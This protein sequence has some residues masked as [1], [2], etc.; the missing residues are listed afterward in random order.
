MEP[1]KAIVGIE[2]GTV[3]SSIGIWTGNAIRNNTIPSCVAF[4]DH[5]EPITG[6]K[7]IEQLDTNVPNTIVDARRLI[8]ARYSDIDGGEDLI[9]LWPF[10]VVPSMNDEPRFL[11]RSLSTLNCYSPEEIVCMILMS[12]KEYAEKELGYNR[13][14]EVVIDAVISVP[15]LFSNSQ[16][17]AT[18]EAARMAAARMR[19]LNPN[20]TETAIFLDSFYEDYA[21][22]V[23]ITQATVQETSKDLF[24]K[25]QKAVAQCLQDSRTF[26]VHQVILVGGCSGI[27]IIREMLKVLCGVNELWE[28]QNQRSCVAQGATILAASLSGEAVRLP[29]SEVTPMTLGVECPEDMPMCNFIP[30]YT[31]VPSTCIRQSFKTGADALGVVKVAVYEGENEVTVENNLLGY[32]IFGGI[33]PAERG[34]PDPII[35]VS[36]AIDNNGTVIVSAVAEDKSGSRQLPRPKMFKRKLSSEEFLQLENDLEQEEVKRKKQ[37][38]RQNVMQFAT[39]MCRE[40]PCE[41]IHEAFSASQDWRIKYAVGKAESLLNENQLPDVRN[42]EYLQK[43]YFQILHEREYTTEEVVVYNEKAAAK[44]KEVQ[45]TQPYYVCRR[46]QHYMSKAEHVVPIEV[47]HSFLCVCY[48]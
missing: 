39:F 46:C 38:A 11:V 21:L 4:T 5:N 3:S 8:G 29:I 12:L 40:V 14:D 13:E 36:L 47:R 26:Q 27:P 37:I 33:E 28:F 2:I 15:C 43:T 35:T 22:N 18:L 10:Q 23:T 31:R 1:K 20:V 45:S 19:L 34:E 9:R 16:K 24:S 44:L 42:L 7:A 17:M 32:F 6:D 48:N 25:C 30:R 41:G